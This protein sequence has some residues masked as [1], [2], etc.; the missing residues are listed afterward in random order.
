MNTRTK[1]FINSLLFGAGLLFFIF[2]ILFKGKLNDYVS[3]SMISLAGSEIKKTVPA[4]IDSAY[5]YNK[6]GRSF[7][8][9]FLEFGAKGCSSCKRMEGVMEEIRSKYPDRVNVVFLNILIPENQNMMKYFGIALIPT[10][11]LLDKDGK[12]FFRHSGFISAEG[13]Q[14]EF[15]NKIIKNI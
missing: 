12:E 2:L 1:N 10:Q 14:K 13:L 15:F 8:F 6:N 5:N 11:V 4:F 3:K 7:Q 9:T